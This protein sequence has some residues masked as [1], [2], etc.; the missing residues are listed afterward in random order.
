MGQRGPLEPLVPLEQLRTV[1]LAR[2]SFSRGS[3][4]GLSTRSP[5]KNSLAA[6]ALLAEAH[7][8][9]LAALRCS[10]AEMMG[11]AASGRLKRPVPQ[12]VTTR[13]T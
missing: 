1:G 5:K 8:V 7:L 2:T 12:G 10:A 4:D 13:C 6:A 3:E 9:A 11:A